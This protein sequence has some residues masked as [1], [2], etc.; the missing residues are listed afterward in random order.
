MYLLNGKVMIIKGKVVCGM[1]CDESM[2]PAE[3]V[4]A[5]KNAEQ[6]ALDYI[7][8]RV[9]EQENEKDVHK[10]LEYDMA[11]IEIDIED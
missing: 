1:G 7:H 4:F 11:N 10:L 6:R 8:K 5:G 3:I 2:S 9:K